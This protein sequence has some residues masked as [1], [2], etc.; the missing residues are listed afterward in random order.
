MIVVRIQTLTYGKHYVSW[1]VVNSVKA[2]ILQS[3]RHEVN[4]NFNIPVYN[5]I[6][7]RTKQK[8]VWW[9]SSTHCVQHLKRQVAPRLRL[10]ASHYELTH[11][12]CVSHGVRKHGST[13]PNTLFETHFIG[14]S[15]HEKRMLDVYGK[16]DTET[17]HYACYIKLLTMIMVLWH[18]PLRNL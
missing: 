5:V 15:K 12:R 2:L 14:E 7:Q 13:I 18:Q 11:T 3:F 8:Q 9:P 17:W 10:D 1:V 4:D 6:K 16:E